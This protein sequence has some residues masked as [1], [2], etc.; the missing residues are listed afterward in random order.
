MSRER[1]EELLLSGSEVAAM[2]V[3]RRTVIEIVVSVSAVLLFVGLIVWIGHSF[4]EQDLTDA[5]GLALVGA[6]VLFIAV[7]TVIGVVLAYV[8]NRPAK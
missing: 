5:G 8:L 6:I 7:M 2:D 3:D 4:N 1:F